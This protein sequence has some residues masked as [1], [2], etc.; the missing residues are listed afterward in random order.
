MRATTEIQPD[1]DDCKQRR[2]ALTRPAQSLAPFE[3]QSKENWEARK[4]HADNV[5]RIDDELTRLQEEFSE[6]RR[7]EDIAAATDVIRDQVNAY[8]ELKAIEGIIRRCA[9]T[10]RSGNNAIEGYALRNRSDF[11]IR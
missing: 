10:F 4:V 9:E 11:P 2:A 3:K 6:A 7:A 1:I 8:Q 5:A